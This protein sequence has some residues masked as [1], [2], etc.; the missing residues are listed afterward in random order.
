ML[1]DKP[2]RCAAPRKGKPRVFGRGQDAALLAFITVVTIPAVAGFMWGL[3]R[4]FEDI[5]E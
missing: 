5:G 3:F 2:D 1:D 4:L